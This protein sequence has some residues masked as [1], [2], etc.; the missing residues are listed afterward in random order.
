MKHWV[1]YR[2]A[3]AKEPG[4]NVCQDEVSCERMEQQFSKE[5]KGYWMILDDIGYVR[6]VKASEKVPSRK[7]QKATSESKEERGEP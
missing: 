7:K 2:L 4:F 3:L 5:S 6:H 1:E